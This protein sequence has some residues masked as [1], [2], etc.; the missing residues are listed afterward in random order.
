MFGGFCLLV[1]SVAEVRG[2]MKFIKDDIVVCFYLTG[3]AYLDALVSGVGIMLVRW[4]N[5]F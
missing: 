1:D 2:F 4:E 3:W 5:M